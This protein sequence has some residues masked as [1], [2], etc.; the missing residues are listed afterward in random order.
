MRV[1]IVDDNKTTRIILRKNLTDWGYTVLE[2]EDGTGAWQLYC[3]ERPH[4]L[5]TDLRMPGLDGLALLQQIKSD[6][7]GHSCDVIILTGHGDMESVIACLRAGAYDYLNKPLNADELRNVIE[8]S[9]DHQSLLVENR[10]LKVHFEEQL[11]RETEALRQDLE[12][13][14]LALKNVAGVG[15]VVAESPVMQT[16]VEEA[17][18]YHAEPGVPVLIEG[19]TGSGKEVL[20]RLVH[21]GWKGSDKPLVDINCSAM[22]E[23]LFE[24]ELFGYAP[25]SFTGASQKGA[26]GKLALAG[27]GTLFLDE[28]GDMP[29]S[30]QPKLLRVLESR[31]FFPVGGAR[32]FS[33]EARI[34]CATNRDLALMVEEGTFRRDLYH[35]LHVGHIR[36]PPLRERS[37]EIPRLVE[38]FLQRECRQK[39][40]PVLQTSPTALAQLKA[41][42]WPGNVR[43]LENAI[44]RVVLTASGPVLEAEHFAFLSDMPAMPA[45]AETSDTEVLPDEGIDFETY[46]QDLIR[47]VLEKC[48]G[49]RSEAARYLG[50]SRSAFCRRADKLL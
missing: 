29:A 37:D 8:R 38:L 22:S 24:S 40:K 11:N 5:V 27:T 9:A 33:F 50:M 15:E 21:H 20:T 7:S 28:V 19:E 23:S 2:A 45:P 6:P 34:I 42:S 25:G 13:T 14:R 26:R 46:C 47:R 41:Y 44:Q 31:E 4:I 49:N 43:E 1:L 12:Q 3:Q 39:R 35:R 30:L 48:K 10:D 17:I 16:L 36:I 18:A 32:K